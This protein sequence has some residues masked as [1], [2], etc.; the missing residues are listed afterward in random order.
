[1]KSFD[2]ICIRHGERSV[3]PIVARDQFRAICIGISL[4]AGSAD[5]RFTCKPA[6]AA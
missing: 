2:L 5:V 4:L 3:M 1:M 6:R